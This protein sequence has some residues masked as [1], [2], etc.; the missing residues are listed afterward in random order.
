M[1]TPSSASTPRPQARF[2]RVAD[3]VR[4]LRVTIRP[5]AA[6]HGSLGCDAEGAV[7]TVDEAG[8][9]D[10]TPGPTEADGSRETP[11]RSSPVDVLSRRRAGSTTLSARWR[12]A[13]TVPTPARRGLERLICTALTGAPCD[14]GT[15]PA[16]AVRERPAAYGGR[17]GSAARPRT[18]TAST[19]WTW[20]SSRPSCGRRSRR[21]PR[22]STSTR[23][24]RRGASSW[25]GCRAR[26]R[27]RGTIDVLRH[28]IKHGPHHL[29]LFYGTPSPGNAKA[30]ERYAANRFS[31]T[32]QLRY[33]RDETQLALDLVPLHQR[34]A[35]RHL[36]AEEQPHQADGR[37]RRPA[38]QARPRPAREALRVRPLRGAL[39][40]GRPRGALL[41]APQGQGLVVPALQPGLER[42]RGQPAQPG[43]PQDRLP[44]EAHPHPRRA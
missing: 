35:G 26:S 43:R 8:R 19:A 44:L 32:R 9:A 12:D 24:A 18:T 22:R 29:D 30:A 13:M 6:V 23:T 17:A 4:G 2:E 40:R 41:H 27:K 36:R 10:S 5:G 25:P 3:L 21:R 28:G 31:V 16:D 33:S 15:A 38:V 1:L 11:D 37:G 34:P 42:R 39:R 7:Q 20:R 14:P